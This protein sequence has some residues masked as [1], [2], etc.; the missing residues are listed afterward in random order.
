MIVGIT[1]SDYILPS[2]YYE[3]NFDVD[4]K[5]AILSAGWLLLD[6]FF[7]LSRM[8][9]TSTELVD[10]SNRLTLA[11]YANLRMLCY[12]HCLLNK[13]I[14]MSKEIKSHIC[15]HFIEFWKH[16]KINY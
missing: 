1:E 5:T 7:S 11:N 4:L 15:L 3:E 9:M 6:A 14:K 12:K 10:V 2:D 13:P 8:S 16:G